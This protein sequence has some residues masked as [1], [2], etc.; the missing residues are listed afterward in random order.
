[1]K[2]MVD[3]GAGQTHLIYEAN[4]IQSIRRRTSKLTTLILR[5]G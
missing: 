3:D 4:Q 2:R 5:D 1:M